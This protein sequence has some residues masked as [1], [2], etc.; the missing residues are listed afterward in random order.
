MRRYFSLT[1]TFS[2]RWSKTASPRR[3]VKPNF[4]LIAAYSITDVDTTAAEMLTDLDNDLNADN[5][6]W[7]LPR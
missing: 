5:I 1:Q 2:G 3:R 4:V 7:H 6:H